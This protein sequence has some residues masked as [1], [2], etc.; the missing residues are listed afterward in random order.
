MKNPRI[1]VVI[2][3]FNVEKYL[4]RCV[5]SVTG[6]TFRDIEILLIDDGS[7][8]SSGQLCDCLALTDS[9]IRV[10]HK[11]NG[12]LSNA[13]N[14]GI[15]HALGEYLIFIDSDDFIDPDMLEI[16]YGLTVL[17]GVQV[18][19]CTH[20]S[21]YKS[22]GKRRAH[23]RI[24]VCSGQE[25]MKHVMLG[26]NMNISMCTKL[27][28]RD[29]CA[30]H[31]FCEGRTYEDVLYNPGLFLQV[32]RV[33]VTTRPMYHYWH[34]ANS[35]STAPFSP[36]DTDL[37]DA[38]QYLL[39][40][41]RAHWPELEEIALYSLR[42]AK[43][44]LLDKLLMTPDYRQKPIFRQTLSDLRRDWKEIVT[45][46]YFAATRRIA[47]LALRVNLQCYRILLLLYNKQHEA[48]E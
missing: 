29:L 11:A 35:I 13:R 2:P 32:D 4:K 9:R 14:T 25:A 16:L 27:I 28:H 17:Y 37:L 33:A 3:V 46:P 10:L 7:T 18:A 40:Q 43:F 6:Q 15:D 47:A 24:F 36:K 41:V 26:K 39:D 20:S 34:R 31:R 21:H 42:W 30:V 12:G 44:L 8:D 1:T 38:H 19:A 48:N 5:D 22:E 23:E 45:C